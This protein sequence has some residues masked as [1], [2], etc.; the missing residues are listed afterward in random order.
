MG[1]G[2]AGA[3]T[4]GENN[5]IIGAIAGNVITTGARN[6]IIGRNADASDRWWLM[7]V[8]LLGHLVLLEVEV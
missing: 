5:T 8:L 2:A 4:T 7:I 3:I 1:S 6:V